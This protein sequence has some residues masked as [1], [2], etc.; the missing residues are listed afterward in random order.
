MINEPVI[1]ASEMAIAFPRR[2]TYAATLSDYWTITKPEV[3]LLIL[4]ATAAG[5]CLSGSGEL[6]RIAWIRLL[7]TLGGTVLVASGAAALNQWIEHPFD[8][9]MR[10]TA[11]RAIAAGRI[12]PRSAQIFG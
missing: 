6:S 11:R 3:N 10:R 1:L 9:R 4:M 8:A 2:S 7:H 5:F 12:E